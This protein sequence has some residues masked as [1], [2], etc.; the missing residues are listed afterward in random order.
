[1]K[2]TFFICDRCEAKYIKCGD[3][4]EIKSSE[5]PQF[6]DNLCQ[7]CYEERYKH[8]GLRYNKCANLA[9]EEERAE[10]AKD[11]DY[12]SRDPGGFD[13]LANLLRWDG[14]LLPYEP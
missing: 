8:L 10:V 5:A 3:S 12:F 11:Q 9:T 13:N 1:M 7:N 14:F 6:D 4:S 2:A